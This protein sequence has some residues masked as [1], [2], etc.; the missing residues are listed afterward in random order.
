MLLQSIITSLSLAEISIFSLTVPHA[1]LISASST[2]SGVK[3][4]PNSKKN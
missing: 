1:L 4:V 3:K 2:A